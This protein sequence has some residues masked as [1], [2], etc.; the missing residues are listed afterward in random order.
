MLANDVDDSS[1]TPGSSSDIST[2]STPSS[3]VNLVEVEFNGTTVEIA[4][5]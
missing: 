2:T 5:F 1:D 4:E 3:A